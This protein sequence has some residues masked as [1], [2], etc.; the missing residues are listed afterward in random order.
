MKEIVLEI[1]G[2]E[3]K[4]K[5]NSFGSEN[6]EVTVNGKDY[7][8]GLKDLGVREI[9]DVNSKN[10][11]R[12]KPKKVKPKKK[13]PIKNVIK[14]PLPGLILEIQV[15]VGEEIEAGQDILVM[16]A[17]KME[18]EIQA[19]SSGT[20]KEIKVEKGESVYE[21]DILIELE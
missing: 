2:K 18:N 8:V 15:K 12:A 4:V 16:E 3:Y 5:V 10:T 17:M 6:A 19:T 21:G 1:K 11:K 9:P 20:V 7:V 13:K 14:A